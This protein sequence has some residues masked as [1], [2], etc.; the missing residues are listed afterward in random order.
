MCGPTPRHFDVVGL[1]AEASSIHFR[2][3]GVCFPERHGAEEFLA[4]L[5]RI[6]RKTSH[7][8]NLEKIGLPN[9]GP[10][11]LEAVCNCART[12]NV[13]QSPRSGLFRC[14]QTIPASGSP[15]FGAFRTDVKT[16][17]AAHPAAAACLKVRSGRA[18][19]HNEHLE[20]KNVANARVICWGNRQADRPTNRL[21]EQIPPLPHCCLSRA[22]KTTRRKQGWR[23]FWLLFNCCIGICV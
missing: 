7:A 1:K 8:L 4:L 21:H 19:H 17:V 16:S 22:T 15:Y 5:S 2:A 20:Y 13:Y 11:L 12:R 10:A 14:S 9:E 3:L 6:A 23:F 18:G